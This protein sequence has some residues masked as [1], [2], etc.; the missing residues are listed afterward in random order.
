MTTFALLSIGVAA[1]V[2]LL[3]LILILRLHPF[4]ALLLVATVVALAGGTKVTDVVAAV[5]GGMGKTLGH[6]AV[7]IALGAMIGRMIDLSG[8]AEAL[9]SGLVR[10]FGERRI[11][12]ALTMAGF[13]VAI[14]VFFEV[15]VIMLMPVDIGRC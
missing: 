7:I 11:A 9:A 10:R 14:P 3:F 4:I 13:G 1:I 15:A 5:E 2:L 12:M 8:G 6:I